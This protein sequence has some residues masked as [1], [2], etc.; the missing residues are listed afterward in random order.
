MTDFFQDQKM[1]LHSGCAVCG[2]VC[3]LRRVECFL[4]N[5]KI[6]VNIT[7]PRPTKRSVLLCSVRV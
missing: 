5:A 6:V 2:F 3:G 7:G 1:G 4:S